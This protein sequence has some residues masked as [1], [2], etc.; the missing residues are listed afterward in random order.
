MKIKFKLN[1][2]HFCTLHI[3][4]GNFDFLVNNQSSYF[5]NIANLEISIK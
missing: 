4:I 1:N 3:L 2:M 5:I